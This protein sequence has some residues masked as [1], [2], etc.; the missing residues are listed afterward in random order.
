MNIHNKTTLLLP[1]VQELP[2]GKPASCPKCGSPYLAR[3]G[4]LRRPLSD[5]GVSTVSVQRYR[6]SHCGFTFR[7]YPAGVGRARRSQ[8]LVA[9]AALLRSVGLSCTATARVLGSAE[10]HISQATVWRAVR[11][12]GLRETP[13]RRRRMRVRVLGPNESP[14]GH[15][16]GIA[17]RFL[18]DPDSGEKIGVEIW[19][20]GD[21]QLPNELHE[22][23]RAT[24]ASLTGSQAQRSPEDQAPERVASR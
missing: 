23:L 18:E 19:G 15:T 12:A 22:F 13:Q 16:D 8:R 3:H 4:T 9:L 10:A 2:Q 14:E 1:P 24:G 5:T 20:A 21:V 17:L 7:H 11:N 6:C